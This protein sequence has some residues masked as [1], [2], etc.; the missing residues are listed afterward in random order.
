MQPQFTILMS[1]RKILVI[2][3]GGTIGMMVDPDSKALKPFEF[4]N[5]HQQLPMLHL[6]EADITFKEMLPLIDS[7]DTNPD[8]WVR[9]AKM[10]T[11]CQKIIRHA[12]KVF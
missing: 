9:L 2:Y 3:T 11:Y 8:F 1:N 4:K 10:E 6:I 7:S 12:Q 5:I